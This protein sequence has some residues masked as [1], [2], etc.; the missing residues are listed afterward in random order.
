V[1]TL[2]GVLGMVAIAVP[3]PTTTAVARLAATATDSRDAKTRWI[4]DLN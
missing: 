3:M 4:S 2:S 1:I